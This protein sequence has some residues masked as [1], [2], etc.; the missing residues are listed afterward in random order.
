MALQAMRGFLVHAW[1]DLRRDRLYFAGRLEDG[2]S[3]AVIEK[4]WRPS[5]HV[6]EGDLERCKAVL[7]PLEYQVSPGELEDFSGRERLALL[8]FARFA[9]RTAAL[10]KLGQAGI[11][12]PDGDIKPA[13]AFLAGRYIRGPVEIQG[14]CRPGR[15]MDLVFTDAELLPAGGP[16]KAALKITSVDIETNTRDNSVRA[17]GI[18]LADSN[19]AAFSGCV[20]VLAP[21]PAGAGP[22]AR[23][24][25]GPGVAGGGVP[26]Y[27][28]GDVRCR[29]EAGVRAIPE[30]DPDRRNGWNF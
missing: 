11:Q 23:P 19:F 6:Y 30:R 9:G 20:H 29:R 16:E 5:F 24:A 15:E 12:T 27:R 17:V 2:R 8:C 14:E 10:K 28:H 1:A 4:D 26:G 18:S 3:F 22:E 25:G 13:E 21:E 7:L